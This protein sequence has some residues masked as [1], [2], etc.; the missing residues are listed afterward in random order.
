MDDAGHLFSG[1]AL[2]EVAPDGAVRLPEFVRRVIERRG[3]TDPVVIGV[4]ESDPCVTAHLR[5]DWPS[6]RAELERRRL[7]DE[8]AGAGFDEHHRRARRTFGLAEERQTDRRGRIVLPELMRRR[9]RI[10]GL[11]LFIGTGA[12]FEIWNPE[13]ARE[14]GG[15]ELRALAE[16][17]LGERAHRQAPRRRTTR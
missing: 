10:D 1:S 15:E 7:R 17:R 11:A 12:G 6:I 4:H 14:A 2:G 13:V 3:G 5:G 8:A 16:Y 9:G